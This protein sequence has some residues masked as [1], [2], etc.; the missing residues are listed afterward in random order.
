MAFDMSNQDIL[1]L[2]S[3]LGIG[4]DLTNPPLQSSPTNF[5]QGGVQ[6]SSLQQ[7][8]EPTGGP[9]MDNNQGLPNMQDIQSM[10]GQLLPQQSP[11]LGESYPDNFKGMGLGDSAPQIKEPDIKQALMQQILALANQGMGGF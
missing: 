4:N 11:R 7:P 9:Q 6:P 1:Q 2:L 10:S 3:S 8:M 5:Q